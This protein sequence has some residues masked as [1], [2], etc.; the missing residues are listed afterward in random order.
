MEAGVIPGRLLAMYVC[1]VDV[2][3]VKRQCSRL[4]YTSERAKETKLWYSVTT[5][6]A[7]DTHP[8]GSI[9]SSNPPCPGLDKDT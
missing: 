5:Y 6:E 2:A 9:V 7:A 3:V 1:G 4:L 8:I